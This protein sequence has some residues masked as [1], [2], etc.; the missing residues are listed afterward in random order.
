MPGCYINKCLGHILPTLAHE[1]VVGEGH[2]SEYDG[3][4]HVQLLENKVSEAVIV[5]G[6]NVLNKKKRQSACNSITTS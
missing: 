1:K 2:Y 3:F 5:P 4:R 6:N